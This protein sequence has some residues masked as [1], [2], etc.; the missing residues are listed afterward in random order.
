[1]SH[2]PAPVAR[3]IDRLA[4]HA[5]CFHRYAHHPLCEAYAGEVLRVG[6]VRLC[7]GCTLIGL[8]AAMGFIVGGLAP[9]ASLPILG[10]IALV[11]LGWTGAVFGAVW[12]RRLGKVGTRLVPACVAAFLALQGLRIQST[13]GYLLAVGCAAS[14]PLAIRAY[15]HRGPWR[16]PCETCPDR[17][18]QPCPGFRLQFRREKAF[19]RLSARLL[20]AQPV[21]PPGL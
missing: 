8:G 6:R 12:A 20:A 21:D 9:K 7:K 19:R 2:I 10:G 18:G 1:M 11:A 3:R 14:L 5:H 15:R 16:D 17:A 4:G 13:W